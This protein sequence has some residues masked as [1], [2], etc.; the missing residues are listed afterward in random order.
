MRLLPENMSEL[1][2]NLRWGVGLSLQILEAIACEPQAFEAGSPDME[3][4]WQRAWRA[5]GQRDRKAEDDALV[6]HTKAR[7]WAWWQGFSQSGLLTELYWRAARREA[8]LGSLD[9]RRGPSRDESL[10]IARA[11]LRDLPEVPPLD[12]EW[13]Y[14][15]L[16][17]AAAAQL[18][19]FGGPFRSALRHHIRRCGRRRVHF[20][21]LNL[22]Y[23]RLA[24]QGTGIPGVLARWR[25]KVADGS[26]QRPLMEPIPRY[27]PANPD[28]FTRDLHIQFVIEV[29][30]RVG[31][32]PQGTLIS[33]CGI[34]AEVLSPRLSEDTVVRIW[35]ACTWRTSYLPVMRKYSKAMAIRTGLHPIRD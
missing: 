16:A 4:S 14:A 26:L 35:K 30:S 32:R 31:I 34:V 25:Q 27:R 15:A 9:S 20:D 24:N 29:L 18:L 12:P 33:G 21:A 23:E 3:G 1:D 5:V 8:E 22:T 6:D 11:M 13:E 10:R 17:Q 19:M 28:Q 7:V 2:P